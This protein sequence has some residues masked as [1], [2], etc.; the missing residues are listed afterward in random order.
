MI[1]SFLSLLR[2][3]QQK[4]HGGKE[5]LV[6]FIFCA[7]ISLVGW[8][9]LGLPPRGIRALIDLIGI[10]GCADLQPGSLEMYLCSA[11]IGLVAL[12]GPIIMMIFMF[13]IRKSLA[14]WV[15][16]LTPKLPVEARFLVAPALATIIFTIA[17]SGAHK[18]TALQWGILPQILFPSIVGLFTFSIARFGPSL[19]QPLEG[20]FNFRE[21]IPRWLRMVAVIAVPIVIA[22]VIT[23]QES[24]TAAVLK[25]HFVVIVALVNGYLMM[26]PRGQKVMVKARQAVSEQEQVA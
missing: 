13:L 8:F 4:P 24:V 5:A 14:R 22:L 16:G 3:L 17:W 10:R 2:S 15:Q 6:V 18:D 11:K 19:Q 12:A 20:F 7:V 26:T 23:I 25:E 9:P 1:K 21:K